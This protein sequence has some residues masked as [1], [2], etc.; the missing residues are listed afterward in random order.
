MS[1]R[2]PGL[3]KHGKRWQA[4]VRRQGTLYT[5]TFPID[6]PIPLMLQW[7]IA[8]GARTVHRE[9]LTADAAL[10]LSTIKHMPSYKE[11]RFQLETWCEVL[12]GDRPSAAI[13]P[14]EIDAQLSTWLQAGKSPGTVRHY[15]TALVQMYRRLYPDGPNPA[16]RS[17]RPATLP[18][19]PR[20]IPPETILAILEAMP[21]R[22]QGVKGQSRNTVS[23]T[24]A[25]LW[26]LATT[27][28]PHKQLGQLTAE[29]IRGDLLIVPG[30]Q[31]G[32]GA[33][34]R[35]LPINPAIRYALELM[36]DANAWGPFS[37]SSMRHSFR[38]ALKALGLPLT[39]RPY[40]LRHSMG[41]AIYADTRD[42][43]TVARILGH[44]D[45]RTTAIYAAHANADVDSQAL[46]RAGAR[47]KR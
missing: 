34:G 32:K 8:Q 42:L 16:A 1:K 27:G 17:A 39:W 46:G 31:K 4:Y 43:A 14:A 23:Q 40:D 45:Q 3:R 35:L 12:G 15:R 37:T 21:D 13:T 28:I 25:R 33:A 19:A 9:S 29:S 2:Y 6:T 24:K 5:K 47:F 18:R 10:Y 11:R 22:G 20:Y 7:R 36:A 44:T 41:A 38:R 26:L 30:R